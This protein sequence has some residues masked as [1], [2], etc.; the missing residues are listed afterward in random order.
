MNIR[1]L[2]DGKPGHLSQ[3]TGLARAL[4]ELAGGT[5]TVTDLSGK[6][7]WKRL[8][9]SIKRHGEPTPDVI[10]AAGHHTH[11]PLLLAAKRFRAVSILCMK[12]SLPTSLFDLCVIPRHDLSAS[13]KKKNNPHIFETIGAINGIR[14][15]PATP[16]T[17]TLILIGGPS[18]EFSWD[19]SLLMPQ[20]SAISRY[21]ENSPLHTGDLILTTSRRTP[22]DVARAIQASCPAIRVIPVE[23]T[24]PGWV[25]QHL[26]MAKAVWVTE[27]SVSMVYEALSSGAP[28]GILSIPKNEKKKS[29]RISRGLDMLIDEKR[30]TRWSDWVETSTLQSIPTPLKESIRTAEFILSRFPQLSQQAQPPLS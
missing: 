25:A 28:V 20:L 3:T 23:Q 11:L 4:V 21:A 12:P 30:V 26:S 14:L 6:R 17:E 22:P 9:T 5:V 10:I 7:F 8:T 24:K 18:G 16:K 13:L 19:L 1:I 27:D 29:S 2:S 15:T